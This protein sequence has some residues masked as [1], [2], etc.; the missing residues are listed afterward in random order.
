L[1]F[2]SPHHERQMLGSGNVCGQ[3]GAPAES[4]GASLVTR[5]DEAED[6]RTPNLGARSPL[7]DLRQIV[8][9][10]RYWGQTCLGVLRGVEARRPLVGLGVQAT[11]HAGGSCTPH[12]DA[13]GEALRA[14]DQPGPTLPS[15]SLPALSRAGRSSG[16]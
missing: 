10:V 1:T 12:C 4:A 9:Y 7:T 15:T 11:W 2:W 6:R 8:G 3:S 13:A 14:E 16:S 5:D